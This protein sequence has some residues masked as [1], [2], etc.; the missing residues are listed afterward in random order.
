MIC[1]ADKIGGCLVLFALLVL[2][3]PTLGLCDVWTLTRCSV[4]MWHN[5][6]ISVYNNDDVVSLAE[7][8]VSID[9]HTVAV[10]MPRRIWDIIP[11]VDSLVALRVPL[12]DLA[13]TTV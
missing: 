7:L 1:L 13:V 8:H 4:V 9:V 3:G 12:R 6:S 5:Q 10:F 11:D 2:E